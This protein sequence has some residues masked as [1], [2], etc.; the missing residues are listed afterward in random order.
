MCATPGTLAGGAQPSCAPTGPEE[1]VDLPFEFPGQTVVEAVL[2]DAPPV[3]GP[4]CPF[5]LPKDGAPCPAPMVCEYP[6]TDPGGACRPTA[7]CARVTTGD[8]RWSVKPPAAGCGTHSSPC[9]ATFTSLP[10]GAAC[11][12]ASGSLTCDYDKGRCGCVSCAGPGNVPAIAWSC[13]AWAS[14][15]DAGCP[16]E[17]PLAGSPC[18]TPDQFCFYGGCGSISIGSNLQCTDGT[19]Q[20]RGFAGT[21]ALRSCSSL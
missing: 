19:W 1:C 20:P 13:R 18:G 15:A 3:G 12:A 10:A 4:S 6:G 2:P 21:C 9:P 11:P 8:T 14:G 7:T 16:A 17:A 5:A